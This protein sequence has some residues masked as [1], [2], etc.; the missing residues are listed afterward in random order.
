MDFFIQPVA[1]LT[2]K[3]LRQIGMLYKWADLYLTRFNCC[4]NKK[5]PDRIG[6]FLPYYNK[7][8]FFLDKTI[9]LSGV[10][11]PTTLQR[12]GE[13]CTDPE[14]AQMYSFLSLSAR[15]YATPSH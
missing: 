3:L 1:I 15:M 11:S 13:R 4:F 14:Q 7:G 8:S 12:S 2:D 5:A 9:E 6:G 10:C